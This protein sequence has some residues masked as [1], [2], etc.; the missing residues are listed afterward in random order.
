M[1][2]HADTIPDVHAIKCF[3]SET[4][5][6]INASVRYVTTANYLH[7]CDIVPIVVPMA[8]SFVFLLLL[9]LGLH[10]R[11]W[12]D[13]QWYLCTGCRCRFPTYDRRHF[14]YD[15]FVNYSRDEGD[16]RILRRDILPL[17]EDHNYTTYVP[18]RD[19]PGGHDHFEVIDYSIK[20]S[21]TIVLLVSDAFFNNDFCMFTFFEAAA[22]E[23]LERSNRLII[24]Q[25]SEIT[26]DADNELKQYLKSKRSVVLRDPQFQRKLL[27]LLPKPSVNHNVVPEIETLL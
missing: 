21:R 10:F 24:V 3:P 25:T 6:V 17:L 19:W 9:G 4:A 20:N 12:I 18:D 15:V 1:V 14:E 11:D 22:A 16:I 23:K 13:F 5:G 2:R 7:C 8:L 26:I 27:Y